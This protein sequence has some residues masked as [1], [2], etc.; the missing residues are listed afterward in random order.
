MQADFVTYP[1]RYEGFGNALLETVYFRLPLLVNRYNVFNT[2]IAPLGFKL[3]EIDGEICDE[4]VEQ[5]IEST[6]DP[7]I[8]RHMVEFNYQ[9]A[10]EHFSYEAVT[11]KVQVMIQTLMNGGQSIL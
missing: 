2:D 8:R 3:V 4:T 1:S 7:V 5:V 10:L 11:P 9:L 6:I